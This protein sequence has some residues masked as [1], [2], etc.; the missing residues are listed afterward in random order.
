LTLVTFA[1]AKR[2]I[3]AYVLAYNEQRLHSSIGYVTPL[4]K[5]N[6]EDVAIF[7]ERK[8]K[9]VAAR[10]ARKE[11]LLNKAELVVSQPLVDAA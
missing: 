3:A 11:R 10:I 1:E 8:N 5:L 7:I 6:G 9:L 2:V 4:A